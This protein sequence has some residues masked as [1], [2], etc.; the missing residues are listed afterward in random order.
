VDLK[1][2]YLSYYYPADCK[3]HLLHNEYLRTYS[4]SRIIKEGTS[5]SK[6]VTVKYANARYEGSSSW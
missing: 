6:V 1:K 5:T 2:S 3:L 4:T